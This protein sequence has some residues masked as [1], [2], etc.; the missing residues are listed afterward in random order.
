MSHAAGFIHRELKLRLRLKTIPELAFEYDDGL[1][2][3]QH[4]ADLLDTI[5]RERGPGDPGDG[6]TGPGSASGGAS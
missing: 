6:G 2:H 5:K 4:I 1:V 3:A